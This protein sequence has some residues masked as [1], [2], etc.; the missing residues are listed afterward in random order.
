VP[1]AEDSAESHR[2]FALLL[3]EAGKTEAAIHQLELEVARKP[4]RAEASL[5]LGALLRASNS[6]PLG[7]CHR[8]CISGPNTL[9][10]H[11]FNA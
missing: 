5:E 3:H 7:P 4:D 9:S 6:P 11:R 2:Y 10:L 8:V 1:L